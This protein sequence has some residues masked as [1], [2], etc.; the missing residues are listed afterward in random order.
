MKKTTNI[1]LVG[2]MGAGKTTIGRLLAERLQLQFVDADK[3]IEDTTGANIPWIFDVEGEAGFRER[4][5]KAI[6]ELSQQDGILLATG[7][8]AVT[9]DVNRA[10]LQQ[11]GVVVYLYATVEQ[12]FE[13]TARDRN[14]PLLQ[15]DNPRQVLENLFQV[16]DPLYRDVAD[17]IVTTDTR[18]PH[19]VAKD[20]GEQISHYISQHI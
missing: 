5:T 18:P 7:G 2:P 8:G 10:L 14:R 4:E 16:R 1:F 17:I 12:Q 20:I 6:E 3:Y 15:N 19:I 11:R 9:R 13:R